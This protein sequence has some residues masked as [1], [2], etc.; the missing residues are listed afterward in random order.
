MSRRQSDC[1]SSEEALF[2]PHE[3]GATKEP[4]IPRRKSRSIFMYLVHLLFLAI[5]AVWSMANSSYKCDDYSSQA[6]GNIYGALACFYSFTQMHSLSH[7]SEA[8]DAPYSERVT[9]YNLT[10]GEKPPFTTFDTAVADEAW[11]SISMKAG[12]KF[13]I[14]PNPRYLIL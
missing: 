8:S 5:N 7:L 2:L 3:K 13:E 12:R 11:A 9:Q 14:L 10:L 6:R 1:E 4:P